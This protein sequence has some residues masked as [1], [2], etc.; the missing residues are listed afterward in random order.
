MTLLLTTLVAAACGGGSSS[1]RSGPSSPSTLGPVPPSL[2]APIPLA[3]I[4]DVTVQTLRPELRVTNA[5][6][7]QPG[8]RT[9]EFQL[10]ENPESFDASGP[11][12]LTITK[13]GVPEG[14][15]GRTV[16][17]LEQ[18]LPV[19]KRFYWRARAVQLW[20]FVGPYSAPA[21]FKTAMPPKPVLRVASLTA[22]SSRAEVDTEVTLAAVIDNTDT[23]VDRLVFE[24]TVEKG[25]FS[26]TGPI[27]RWRAPRGERTPATYDLQLTVID[28][29]TLVDADG[30]T[31]LRENRATASTRVRVHDS[32]GEL[33]TLALT[34]LGDFA[35]SAVSAE[36]CV[37]NFSDTC[38]GKQEELEDIRDNRQK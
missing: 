3:P 10:A 16:F 22:S 26:G 20:A 7:D 17:Q 30:R 23:P 6:S 14:A 18:D 28:R 34:F 38:R 2:T 21:R 8:E 31:E 15:D 25:A 32:R 36:T 9:Y 27:V 33:T 35:N 37:R 11:G 29:Y 4:D 13:T 5:T 12:V 24:W 19:P 1:Y